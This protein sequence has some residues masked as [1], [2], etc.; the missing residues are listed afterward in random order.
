MNIYHWTCW[1]C[2][3]IQPYTDIEFFEQLKLFCSIAENMLLCD[4]WMLSVTC[5][6]SAE[7]I[8]GNYDLQITIYVTTPG[9]I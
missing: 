4:D 9:G 6:L 2:D 5:E 3:F 8:Q 7:T 1:L